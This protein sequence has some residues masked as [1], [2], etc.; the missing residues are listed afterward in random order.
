MATIRFTI[1]MGILLTFVSR[2]APAQEVREYLDLQTHPIMNFPHKLFGTGFQYFD[3]KHPPKL[4]YNHQ[5][6][7]VNY[8]NYLEYNG[9]AR[10]WCFGL[11]VQ[12]FWITKGQ[13][14]RMVLQ[15]IAYVENFVAQHADKFIIAYSP[16]QV[17]DYV[18]NTDKTIIIF[19][20][21][22]AEKILHSQQ[23]ADFWASKGIAFITLIHLIDG[24]F[25]GA[26]TLPSLPTRLINFRGSIRSVFKP[27]TT[28]GL[29]TTGK[30][31]IL[32]LANAGIM[33]DITHM[34]PQSKQ[35]ALDFMQAKG[36]APISTHDS[37]QPIKND[38]RSF[39]AEQIIQL[40]QSGGLFSLP[41]TM[42][43]YKPYKEYQQR[44]DTM[45]CHCPGS[46]D[47]YKFGY[48]EVQQ[49]IE[50]NAGKLLGDSTLAFD[51]LTEDQKVQLSIGFQTDFN[52]WTN[53][54]RPRYGPKGCSDT[55][56]GHHYL[57]IET[58]GL[59]HPGLLYSQWELLEKEGV[60]LQPLL[61]SSEKFLQLWE[62]FL[63]RKGKLSL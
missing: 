45:K 56:A 33:I 23:D 6:K 4:S 25:G 3:P 40:Y 51:K 28:K 31:A 49:L 11:I 32:W 1:L 17:R 55:I 20:V 5:L 48:Q 52:G 36:L 38:S 9:G 50:K 61:R 27:H 59:R 15:E 43:E 2:E 57:P 29:T 53:H 42:E 26:A 22:G 30:Q 18:K 7:N 12:E 34:S 13:A 14:R 21:E 16:Q 58:E 62:G 44:L 19:S 41:V 24:K 10:I 35:D 60:D 46:V 37:Y 54:S 8:A 63:E 47:S 39:T